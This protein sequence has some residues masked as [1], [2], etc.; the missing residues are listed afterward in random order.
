MLMEIPYLGFLFLWKVHGYGKSR[1]KGFCK[2]LIVR[3]F[4]LKSALI[5]FA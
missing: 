3:W 4:W 2:A 1:A 5:L